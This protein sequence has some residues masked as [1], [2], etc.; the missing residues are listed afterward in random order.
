MKPTK[1][2]TNLQAPPFYAVAEELKVI[3]VIFLGTSSLHQRSSASCS[4]G[5]ILRYLIVSA[6]HIELRVFIYK[7]KN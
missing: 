1:Q 7:E 3:L 6:V 5:T 4:D 2:K